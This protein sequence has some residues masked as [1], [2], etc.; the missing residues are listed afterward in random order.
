MSDFTD[1]PFWHV[2]TQHGIAG[3]FRSLET[4]EAEA[5]RLARI[6]PGREHYVMQPVMC[7][8]RDDLT[9]TRFSARAAAE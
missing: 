9:V 6:Y 2:W 8:V 7:A 4:A 3:D 5:I 1:P